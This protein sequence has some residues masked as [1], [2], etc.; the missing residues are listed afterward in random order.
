MGK[1]Y[2]NLFDES[3]KNLEALTM[4]IT[5]GVLRMSDD[6]RLTQIDVLHEDMQEKLIFLRRFNNQSSLLALQR[7]RQENEIGLQK[8]IF[9][10]TN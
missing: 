6:E 7:A 2:S 3:L 8:Q 10:V 4:T 5:S 1:V 9:G